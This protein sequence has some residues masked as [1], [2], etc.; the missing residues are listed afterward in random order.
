[1]KNVRKFLKKINMK[2]VLLFMIIIFVSVSFSYYKENIE[3]VVN[4]NTSELLQQIID[5]G[6]DFISIKV[7]DSFSKMEAMASFI[8]QYDDIQC[9]EVLDA[10]SA[11][12]END[13]LMFSGVIKLDGSGVTINGETFQ[14]DFQDWY[15]EEALS[16]ERS[17]SGVLKSH[18]LNGEYIILAVP[19]SQNG[20]ITGVLQC[21]YDIKMFTG[22]IGETTIGKKGTTF[23]AQSDGTLVSRPDAIGKYTNL[24]DLLDSFSND[25]V[26]IEKLKKQIQ[27]NES[28]ILTFNTGKYKRY[29]C[30][31]T[32]PSTEWHAVS[33][34]S[35]S[36]IEDV[37]DKITR[38]ALILSVGITVVFTIYIAYWFIVN[39]INGKR[40]HMKEQRYHIVANQSDS[41]V[42][43]CNW[44]DKTVYHTHKWEEKFGYPPV[45]ENYLENMIEQG[46]VYDE[47]KD[48]F[49]GIFKRLEEDGSEYEEDFVRINNADKKPVQ[50]KIR[51]TAIRNRKNKIIRVVGKVLEIKNFSEDNKKQV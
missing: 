26:R 29:V 45:T 18:S 25:K 2:F 7:D 34:V 23:I 19:I 12:N 8:G 37:T 41:I 9:K 42:F 32:I 38:Y 1:M 40:M 22:L 51:A 31:S 6:T 50:C 43:E 14:A 5:E 49:L 16:G 4:N 47:D 39:Y 15:F 17:I 30:Y 27:K 10:L 11:Q 48:R 46:I 44:I 36:E 3:T 21:A 28:D 24:F 35:A 33:I 13:L 20:S